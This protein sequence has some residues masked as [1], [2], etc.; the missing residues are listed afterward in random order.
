MAREQRVHDNHALLAAQE[1]ALDMRLPLV[2]AFNLLPD[3]SVRSREQYQFMLDGLQQLAAELDRLNISFVLRAGSAYDQ[4][5]KLCNELVPAQIFF[6][7]SPLRHPRQ[8]QKLI[9]QHNI[10][11]SVV[12]AHNIIPI[13]V[14][15][16]KEEYAAHTFRPKL[17][18]LLQQWLQEPNAIRPHPY[19]L[20]TVPASL[21]W[22]AASKRIA[23]IKSNGTQVNTPS[24]ELAARQALAD[25][26]D[27]RLDCYATHRNDPTINGQSNLSP[28]LH[29]GQ[30]AS[31]R[32][33]LQLV[34]TITQ[35]PLL[36]ERAKMPEYDTPTRLDSV[37]VLLE[38]LVVRKELADNYCFYNQRYDSLEG[39]RE[40]ALKTLTEHRTDK[41][42]YAY[43]RAEWEAACTHDP[44]W[45]AAQKQ[46]AQTGK[47][48]GYMRMYWAK[49]ILEWSPS[50]E[51]AIKTAIYLNDTYSIDGRD[52]NGYTG[53]MW[54][55]AG[56]HDRP[57]AE[58]AVFGKVRYM[59]Y[60]GLTR[61][62]DIEVYIKQWAN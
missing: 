56:V 37:N 28:Y 14:S 30:L 9:A 20:K 17:H 34:S 15:S 4:V 24:G 43:M 18:R 42:E 55:I 1:A 44:A 16:D 38:E 45:N 21:S 57:W 13:W 22:Q 26:I 19:Q 58:R 31:M 51:E 47:M 6:D 48:H 33:A 29:F 36:F 50:P 41:R 52:P 3:N 59:N 32:V 40:W 35:Q 8:L 54:S 62:F 60:S 39:A 27:S 25:F 5:L 49:K 7:F 11:T 53:I 10:A 46:L 23:Q 2:V 61:K 12:D